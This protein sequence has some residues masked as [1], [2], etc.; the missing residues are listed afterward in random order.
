ME[1]EDDSENVQYIDDEAEEDDSL[2]EDDYDEDEDSDSELMDGDSLDGEGGYFED[3]GSSDN[4]EFDDSFIN[5][6]SEEILEEMDS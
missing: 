5:D 4:D 3:M 6:D 2:Q 1:E